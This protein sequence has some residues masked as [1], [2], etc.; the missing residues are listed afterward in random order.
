MTTD[1]LDAEERDI[2]QRFERG[3]L[4]PATDFP[5]SAKYDGDWV[6][7]NMMGPNAL[8]LTESLAECMGLK[9]GMRVLDMGCGK[10]LSSVFLAKEYGVQVWAVDLWIDAT[11][12]FGRI[13]AAGVEDRVF[14]VHAEAHATPFAD[15]FFD[16][17]VSVDA[18][19]YF[20][21]GDLYLENHMAGL[22]KPGGPMG[23]VVPGLV[24][25]LPS[26]EPPEHLRPYWE[27]AMFSLHSPAWWQ[28]HWER[29]GLVT[30]ELADLLPEGWKLWM[31]SDLL[32]SQ[33]LG[34]PADE[35]EMLTLD[36]G[37]TLGFTRMAA[38][39]NERI[40]ARLDVL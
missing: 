38:R 11:D 1:N 20:G 28:R 26:S 14:P 23:I 24:E 7:E 13:C 39:R 12:N 2:L 40:P 5:R 8:W 9:P 32:W 35:A 21:T 3:E 10:G 30:V 29:S 33:R 37:R 36:A 18:Y 22:V 25:E 19:H 34:K 4:R 15:G 31:E 17:M 6:L 27:P 16:A